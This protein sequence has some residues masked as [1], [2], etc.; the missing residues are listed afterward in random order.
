LI[1]ILEKL[2]EMSAIQL[3]NDTLIGE[4][5]ISKTTRI[6]DLKGLFNDEQARAAMPQEETVYEVS[7][8][9]PVSEGTP[10][11]LFFGITYISPGLVGNEYYM[12]RGHFHAQGDRAEFYWGLKG[13][14]Q[15]ILMDRERNTR[16]EEMKPGSLHYIPAHT[17]H[18]VANTGGET[19][20][21]A[22][23][24]P[25]DAG[26]D[27]EEIRQHGFSARVLRVNGQ[28]IQVVSGQSSTNGNP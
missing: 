8:Y 21:F 6:S 14:G 3:L 22:A 25:A 12:T 1:N 20:S 18:R 23:C 27:Y 19:L 24:W 5:V 7:L 2:I 15:L 4:P 9:L 10:G 28:P 16:I 17:A 26:Y 13:S 11:G